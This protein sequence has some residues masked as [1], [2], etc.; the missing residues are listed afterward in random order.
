MQT[1]TTI[2]GHNNGGFDQDGCFEW[3]AF[4]RISDFPAQSLPTYDIEVRVLDG[5]YFGFC[6][7]H[8]LAQLP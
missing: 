4:I 2:H 7:A 3:S 1:S 5:M 6:F 8:L